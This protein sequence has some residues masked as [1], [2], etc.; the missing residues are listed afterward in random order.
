MRAIQSL[1][2]AKIRIE[3]AR[4]LSPT[5]TTINLGVVYGE[6]LHK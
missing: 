5:E 1:Q 3:K 4:I 2:T 6:L